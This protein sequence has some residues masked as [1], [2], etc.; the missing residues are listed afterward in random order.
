MTNFLTQ[1]AFSVSSSIFCL[2]QHF[3]SQ[4]AVLKLKQLLNQ[5]L[6]DQ[7]LSQ[8]AVP[9]PPATTDNLARQRQPTSPTWELRSSAA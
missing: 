1:A 9:Q 4:L 2:K 5:Q 3:L 6:T 7:A 8:Q